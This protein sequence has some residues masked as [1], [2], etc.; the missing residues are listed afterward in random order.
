MKMEMKRVEIEAMENEVERVADDAVIQRW[1]KR[2]TVGIWIAS[3]HNKMLKQ[4]QQEDKRIAS[5]CQ[6]PL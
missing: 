2:A 4:L 3:N 5:P 1:Q 6:V